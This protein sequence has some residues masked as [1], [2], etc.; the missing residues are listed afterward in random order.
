MLNHKNFEIYFKVLWN[1]KK[2]L[3]GRIRTHHN[4]SKFT[5]IAQIIFGK[6]DPLFI[7][8]QI[9]L[10]KE[11]FYPVMIKSFLE[12]VLFRTLFAKKS[13]SLMLLVSVLLVWDSRI[14]KASHSLLSIRKDQQTNQLANNFR[15][16]SQIE[17]STNIESETLKLQFQ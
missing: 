15:K 7:D 9:Q 11:Y 13:W 6:P 3:L 17:L 16:Y 10:W 12:I 8:G 5:P 2:Q 14:Q 1:C 4:T